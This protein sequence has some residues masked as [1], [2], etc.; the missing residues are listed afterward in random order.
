M[1][2]APTL[3][4]GFSL[5]AG[6]I[7]GAA[8]LSLLWSGGPFE[9]MW[10]LRSPEVHAQ[11]L[12]LGW[13]VGLVLALVA[14]IALATGIGGFQR[15]RWAWVI[16][17]VGLAVNG[18]A[19]VVRLAMGQIIEGVAGVVIAGLILLLLLLP[20]VRHQFTR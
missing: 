9:W 13:P 18:L 5:V 19:D 12:A 8:A 2:I 3:L 20:S 4:G 1:R 7:A 14:L 6:A 17:V 15:R 10:R 16:A 11:M